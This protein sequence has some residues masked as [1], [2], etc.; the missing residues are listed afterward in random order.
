MRLAGGVFDLRNQ[1]GPRFGTNFDPYTQNI[2]TGA[3]LGL[4]HHCEDGGS[5]ARTRGC[6]EKLHQAFCMAELKDADG[7]VRHDEYGNVMFCHNIFSVISR[8]GCGIH[9]YKYG[10]NLAIKDVRKGLSKENP[11]ENFQRIWPDETEVTKQGLMQDDG[12][13]DAPE[14]K[15]TLAQ[16]MKEKRAQDFHDR[17]ARSKSKSV[18]VKVE[19]SQTSSDPATSPQPRV[20]FTN[21]IHPR[22]LS[23]GAASNSQT[24]R[25]TSGL[26]R[27]EEKKRRAT[28]ETQKRIQD[29]KAKEEAATKEKEGKQKMR[30]EKTSKGNP[31][32]I[33]KA[34]KRKK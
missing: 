3:L 23:E 15:M 5:H 12:E 29:D 11:W 14:K 20:V 33:E 7:N 22:H 27:K 32:W 26:S 1:Y 17:Y 13:A 30:S 10:Y 31:S 16:T 19:S 4:S 21:T 34:V 24:P 2:S 25:L 6:F 28:L 8:G 9:H 18:G